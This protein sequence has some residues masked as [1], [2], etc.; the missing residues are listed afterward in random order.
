MAQEPTDTSRRGAA[1]DENGSGGRTGSSDARLGQSLNHGRQARSTERRLLLYPA[2]RV[3]PPYRESG[4][5]VH[6]AV[7]INPAVDYRL[8]ESCASTRLVA[9]CCE[10]TIYPL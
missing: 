8:C 2:Q 3:T 5:A 6:R 9:R 7:A 1:M 4:T 10:D